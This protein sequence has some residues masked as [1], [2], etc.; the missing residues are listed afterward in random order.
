[1]TAMT[2]YERHAIIW[3]K[4]VVKKKKKERRETSYGETQEIQGSKKSK[5]H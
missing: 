1:M 4:I 2:S 3:C 5:F